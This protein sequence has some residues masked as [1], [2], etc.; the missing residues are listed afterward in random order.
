MRMRSASRKS[1]SGSSSSACGAISPATFRPTSG[2]RNARPGTNLG[3]A[4]GDLP[5]ITAGGGEEERA[6]DRWWRRNALAQF[7]PAARNYLFKVL[8]VRKA[9]LLTAQRA[10]PHSARD[11]RDFARL[12]EGQSSAQAMRA[13]IEFEFP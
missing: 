9:R 8:E 4:I 13:G 10:L 12:A 11:L 1:T 7:G 2:P 6:Y 5:P 3:A